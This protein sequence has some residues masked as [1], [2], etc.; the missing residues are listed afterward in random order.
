MSDYSPPCGRGF[1]SGDLP[2]SFIAS[3]QSGRNVSRFAVALST[4]MPNLSWTSSWNITMTQI[5]K[6]ADRHAGALII[7]AVIGTFMVKAVYPG[8]LTY[9]LGMTAIIV[10]V[11]LPTVLLICWF[12][13]LR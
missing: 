12:L 8:A 6:F 13:G 10:F 1:S 5:E 3:H 4:S 11:G 7:L 9:A 2:R